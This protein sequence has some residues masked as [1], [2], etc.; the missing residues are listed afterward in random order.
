M[1]NPLINSKNDTLIREILRFIK[2]NQTNERFWFF[3]KY[4]TNKII[5]SNERS[6]I[7]TLS[8]YLTLHYSGNKIKPG[9]WKVIILKVSDMH[10][11]HEKREIL[12]LINKEKSST[13]QYRK[14][15]KQTSWL[16]NDLRK[17]FI[18]HND[19]I[20]EYKK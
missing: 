12:L 4:F 20:D 9:D 1:L 8:L 5:F 3:E 10:W 2:E 14:D 19:F 17:V 16:Y 13:K 11:N 15:I 7:S 6:L 18:L